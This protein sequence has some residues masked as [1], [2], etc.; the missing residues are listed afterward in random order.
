[1]PIF[2]YECTNCR[3]RV[4]FF[5]FRGDEKPP[6]RCPKCKYKLERIFDIGRTCVY[7]RGKNP[8]WPL[9]ESADDG[10]PSGAEHD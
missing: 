1:M 6:Q 10:K 8:N 9:T 5:K 2:E 4:E 3:H 7:K